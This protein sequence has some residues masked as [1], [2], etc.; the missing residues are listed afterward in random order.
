[1]DIIGTTAACMLG[2]FR[3]ISGRCGNLYSDHKAQHAVDR[4]IYG[5]YSGT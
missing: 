4:S 5:V 1:M 3:Y 2:G